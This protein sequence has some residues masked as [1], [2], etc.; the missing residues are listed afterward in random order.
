M[1][2]AAQDTTLTL[3]PM[4]EYTFTTKDGYFV[5]TP[6][7]EILSRKSTEI[8]FRVPYG[9]AEVSIAIKEIDD[10]ILTKTYEVVL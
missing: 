6:R 10:N 1:Q 5:T 3:N 4:T 7:V 2:D 9:I 8:V